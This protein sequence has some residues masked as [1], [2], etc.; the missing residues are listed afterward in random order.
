M[1][2]GKRNKAPRGRK[3]GKKRKG[4]GRQFWPGETYQLA[5]GDKADRFY[6]ADEGG[7]LVRV[8]GPQGGG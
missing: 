8:S 5:N 7:S 2:K 1:P 3:A 4:A 6:R